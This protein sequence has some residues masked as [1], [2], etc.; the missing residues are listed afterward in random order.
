MLVINRRS[1]QLLC[2]HFGMG[3]Q[4]KRD[5]LHNTLCTAKCTSLLV[6]MH[7]K[8]LYKFFAY[9]NEYYYCPNLLVS[10]SSLKKSKDSDELDVIADNKS[11]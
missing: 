4:C 8:E 5:V 3:V 6:F 9:V 10:N 11:D 2:T 1:H 7:K